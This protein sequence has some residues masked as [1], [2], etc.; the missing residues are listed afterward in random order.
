M[1]RHTGPLI[2]DQED[3]VE[4]PKEAGQESSQVAIDVDSENVVAQQPNEA[5]QESSQMA[6]DVDPE[7]VAA[8]QPNEAGHTAPQQTSFNNRHS[9]STNALSRSMST[10][11]IIPQNRNCRKASMPGNINFVHLLNY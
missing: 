11:T 9:K 6:I 7:N 8:Q 4:Q 3:L 5:G 10:D 2:L 1:T